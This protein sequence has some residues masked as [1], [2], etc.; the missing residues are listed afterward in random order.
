M[1]M[2]SITKRNTILLFVFVVSVALVADMVVLA[3]NGNGNVQDDQTRGG[4]M[5]SNMNMGNTTNTN[6][7]GS[8][9]RRR[10]RPAA[11]ANVSTDAGAVSGDAGMQGNANTGNMSGDASMTMNTG[12]GRRR[13]RRRAAAAVTTD[14]TM[15]TA[16]QNTT[17][18]EQTDLSGTYTGSF[19]CVPSGSSGAGS[20]AITGNQFTWT[21]E[22]GG[23][24]TTGRVTAVTTRGYTGV[25]M[26]WG[27]SVA[28]PP[29]QQPTTPTIVSLRGRR[30][31]DR[32]TLTPVP[33]DKKDCSFTPPGGGGG[34]RRRGR[35]GGGGMN[36]TTIISTTDVTQ[37]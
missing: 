23:S 14:A 4:Q 10:R 32:L 18:S 7:S 9:R 12:G 36:M 5:T 11:A 30:S 20:L 2:S 16:T 13:R 31:G 35:R 15:T 28:P 34:R 22:G 27:E 19:D 25:A 3:Q 1:S 37:Q 24:P 26:Q 33:N 21:P 8:R 17:V 6:T 29:G